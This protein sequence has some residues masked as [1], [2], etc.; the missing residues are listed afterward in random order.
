MK[1]LDAD[2]GTTFLF[3]PEGGLSFDC[4]TSSLANWLRFETARSPR[5]GFFEGLCTNM[6]CCG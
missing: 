1:A 3:G 5:F 4:K 2:R 6:P